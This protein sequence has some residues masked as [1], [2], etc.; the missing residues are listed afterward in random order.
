MGVM[1]CNR[2]D[3]TNIMCDRYSFDHGYLCDE[4][5]EELK[6]FVGCKQLSEDELEEQIIKFMNHPKHPRKPVDVSAMNANRID[7]IFT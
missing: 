6:K 1:A 7:A 5:L 4:C 2:K 3:C